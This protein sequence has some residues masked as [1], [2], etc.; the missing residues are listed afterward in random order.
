MTCNKGFKKHSHLKSHLCVQSGDMPYRCTECGTDSIGP[1]HLKRHFSCHKV[2]VTI[3]TANSTLGRDQKIYQ[4][5]PPHTHTT[6]HIHITTAPK[7]QHTTPPPPPPHCYHHD[8]TSTTT[9]LPHTPNS[10]TPLLL[11]LQH[12]HTTAT[13]TPPH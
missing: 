6:T 12:H 3:Q 5:Q 9:T 1:R 10:T 8:H 7:H 4:Q 11:Q 2:K 13:T